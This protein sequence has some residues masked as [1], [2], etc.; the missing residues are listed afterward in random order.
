MRVLE[1]ASV[2]PPHV[3]G[4]EVCVYEISKRLAQRGHQVIVY[5]TNLPRSKTRECK[6]GISI[7]RVPVLFT[8]FGAPVAI[9]LRYIIKEEVD[10][11]H[12]HI[13]PIFGALS[14]LIASRIKKV[15]VVLTYHSDTIGDSP[16]EQFI[17]IIYNVVLDSLILSNV[18]AIVVPSQSQK[19]ELC[20]RGISQNRIRVINNGFDFPE[21]YM[22]AN[23]KIIKRRLGL[24]NEKIVLFV[25]ALEKRK[26]VEY[27]LRATSKVLV[28]NENV[29]VIV[30]GDGSEK[31]SLQD[32][33]RSL[34]IDHMVSFTG[35]VT[36]RRLRDLY[37][38]SDVFVLPSLH[39]TFG[40]VLLEAM[41]HKKP[42]VAT[43]TSGAIE[44]VKPGFNGLL[45]EQRDPEQLATAIIKILSR[46]DYGQQLGEN[47]RCFA[48]KFGW[49]KTLREYAELYD[50]VN[51]NAR[52]EKPLW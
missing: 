50:Q 18:R 19:L 7:R 40:L 39:E 21:E 36:D 43:K 30:V 48:K 47:G 11:I 4:L 22:G 29:K 25:G 24:Q 31:S 52:G 41:S 37:E 2:F 32:L 9:F 1:V 38:I 6:D 16:F 51:R 13:P 27:L 45:V 28:E 14:S 44:L 12:V 33:A 5:S 17:A 20:R 3:G 15:P 26:G 8:V 23:V 35:Y 42:I 10:L 49:E 46:K 34:K